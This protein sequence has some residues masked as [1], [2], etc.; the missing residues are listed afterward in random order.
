MR[1]TPQT[2]DRFKGLVH[3]ETLLS[4][5]FSNELPYISIRHRLYLIRWLYPVRRN[6]FRHQ[7]LMSY[8]PQEG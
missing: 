4:I 8:S 3:I 7:S 6:H 2:L 5:Q 1:A